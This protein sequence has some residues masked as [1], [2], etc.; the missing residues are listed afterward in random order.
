MLSSLPIIGMKIRI[1][2][3]Q[4]LEKAPSAAFGWWARNGFHSGPPADFIRGFDLTNQ[5]YKYPLPL[6][7]AKSTLRSTTFAGSFCSSDKNG[8]SSSRP[9]L[10]VRGL[11]RHARILG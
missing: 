11:S 1:L 7:S 10:G 6:V 3:R 9:D 2:H 5:R 8:K 4:H